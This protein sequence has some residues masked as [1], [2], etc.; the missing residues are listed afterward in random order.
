[1]NKKITARLMGVCIAF[2]AFTLHAQQGSLDP[3]FGT[4]GVAL[5]DFGF[6]DLGYAMALQ[7]DGKIVVG[8]KSGTSS[9][10]ISVA[11]YN[12]NG[13]LDTTFSGDG[14]YLD[15]LGIHA[16]CNAVC[17]QPDG[18]IVLGGFANVGGF[19][20]F[21]MRLN[22]N[23]T[24]DTSYDFDG[25][26]FAQ[27]LVYNLA[28]SMALQP[29]G[30]IVQ[31]GKT[32]TS[33]AYFGTVRYN[34]DGSLDSTFGGTG[35]VLTGFSTGT[36]NAECIALQADGK[37]LVGGT[38]GSYNT[39][40]NVC[41][42]R[43]NTDGSID[44]TFDADGIL[45]DSISAAGLDDNAKAIAVQAD[46]KILLSGQTNTAAG[47]DFAVYRFNPD[48]T[49]DMMFDG[50][51]AATASQT[52]DDYAYG[53][54]LQPD[55]KIIVVGYGSVIS[56]DFL[57][58][59]FNSDGS[60]DVTFDNDGLVYSH[61]GNSLS[62][63]LAAAVQPDSKIVVAGYSHPGNTDFAVVR[64]MGCASASS[65][66]VTACDAFTSPSG[67]LW[68]APGIYND[69]IPN[70]AGCDSVI[71]VNLTLLQSTAATFTL[72]ACDFYSTPNHT[73]Y[74]DGTYFDTIPNAAGCDSI[75]TY[76]LTFSYSNS[77]TINAAACDSYPSPSG[78]Y[79]W[80][81]SGTY[82]DHLTNSAGC[83]SAITINLV[84]TTVNTGVTQS[85]VSLS[86]AASN[87]GYQWL[88]C[89]NNYTPIIGAT[90][91]IFTPAADG[92]Y[93]V[94]VTENSCSDT[95]DCYTVTGVGMN[96]AEAGA[97]IKVFPNPSNGQIVVSSDAALSDAT[98]K[99]V[100]LTGQVIL[101]QNNLNG[102]RFT[103]DISAEAA[104]IYFV[105]VTIGGTVSRIKLVKE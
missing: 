71:T 8:G 22:A 27:L 43:Y 4:G 61:L 12:A 38:D 70:A 48:G 9:Y 82:T 59:R 19:K 26:A 54:T 67:N 87:A 65:I 83:D 101:Q 102:P 84:I 28:T 3:S 49:R 58:A 55:G 97:G 104:G 72:S 41:I 64:Y 15:T 1:M 98:V 20:Y 6:E 75:I 24:R 88:D 5:T 76:N 105:E 45:I 40:S 78:L 68:T 93:A 23:G 53:M 34:T 39:N 35:I 16:T 46:G 2:S 30:K 7:S 99:I 37:I 77:S 57:V 11:R 60:L 18:K 81:S 33:N 62:V 25:V 90:S 36:N 52:A 14:K 94:I 69:T 66:S 17:I 91:Q 56:N 92:S 96:E 89:N 44:S 73:W 47:W 80:T 74:V 51:G 50:D 79:T 10:D 103:F 29:D 100:S 31:T 21:T 95:S 86:A 63:A 32:F 42:V 85:G 13:T